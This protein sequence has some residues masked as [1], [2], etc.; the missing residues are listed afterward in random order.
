MRLVL[1]TYSSSSSSGRSAIPSKKPDLISSCISLQLLSSFLISSIYFVGMLTFLKFFF[2]SLFGRT[3]L[4]RYLQSFRFPESNTLEAA[5]VNRFLNPSPVVDSISNC[6]SLTEPRMIFVLSYR[7][8]TEVTLSGLAGTGYDS[9]SE[10]T[11][12]LL[13]CINR[14]FSTTFLLILECGS[15]FGGGSFTV[16]RNVELRD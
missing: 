12:L 13:L 3:L 10:K 7:S 6:S 5:S 1:I 9:Q 4:V 2:I 8:S 16:D 11:S 15:T 14:S